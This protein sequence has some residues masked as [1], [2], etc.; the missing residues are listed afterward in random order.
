MEVN[1]FIITEPLLLQE[2]TGQQFYS[3]EGC[4]TSEPH[5][6]T[7]YHIPHTHIHTHAHPRTGACTHTPHHRHT[8]HTHTHTDT[9]PHTQPYL[10]SPTQT[11]THTYSVITF[12]H[13]GILWT[14][15]ALRSGRK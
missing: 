14:S 6:T 4:L 3:E 1:G 12:T 2:R 9:P 15:K 5:T 13:K 10:H 11:Y 8:R 7:L